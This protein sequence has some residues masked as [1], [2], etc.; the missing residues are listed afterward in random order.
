[1][2]GR[3]WMQV[4]LCV[5]WQTLL[6]KCKRKRAMSHR[7]CQITTTKYA[8]STF[9]LADTPYIIASF[10]LIVNQGLPTKFDNKIRS[11][12]KRDNKQSWQWRPAYIKN[13][14]SRD[15]TSAI[16][17]QVYAMLR[18]NKRVRVITVNS[19]IQEIARVKLHNSLTCLSVHR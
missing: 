15:K 16:E 5:F 18:H 3:N 19:V 12:M 8:R 4:L 7:R 1:M 2:N 6:V 10:L 14:H 13:K 11:K 9:K 17:I